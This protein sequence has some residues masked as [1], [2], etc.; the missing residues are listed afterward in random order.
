[1]FDLGTKPDR[2]FMAPR[3]D[4]KV[5]NTFIGDNLNKYVTSLEYESVDGLADE[6]R[7]SFI[8]PEFILS[9][10]KLWQPGNEIEIWIGFGP[11]LARVGRVIITRPEM[12]FPSDGI[13]MINVVGYTRDFLMMQH[14]PAS[15]KAA[16]RLAK[17]EDRI[18]DS[19]Y[20]IS[21]RKDENGND[22]YG[23]SVID[24]DETPDHRA[25]IQKADMSDYDYIK[26]LA[27]RTGFVFWVDYEEK[28]WA[29]HFRNPSS[30]SQDVE[31]TF[32]YGTDKASII[33][34]TPELALDGAVTKLQVRSRDPE[35]G[36]VLIGEF[37]D[38]LESPDT[39]FKGNAE[40]EVNTSYATAG[41]VT[42]FFFGDYA[43]DVVSD[44]K[45]KTQSD[46][47]Q[48]AEQWYRR[49]R[50]NF[51][52]GRGTLI[53]V[54]DVFSRQTHNLSLPVKSLSGRY[55]FSRVRHVF[56]ENGYVL[57]FTARKEIQG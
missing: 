17:K 1:M 16:S 11:H 55:Y 46:M 38:T 39:K 10:S 49:K 44:K 48:F 6:A 43:I 51:I 31:Y 19:V 40:E 30:L 47:L 53:G 37:N 25:R 2:D 9:N 41:A 22:I 27:S 15:K 24:I 8:N 29:F 32:E 57:D 18:S 54:E 23:F 36:K 56:S 52:I 35:T 42:R 12:T 26:S 28:G 13:P 4:I 20:R 34:F 21:Q 45:F 7:I 14:K 50:E 5:G 33:E 3:F